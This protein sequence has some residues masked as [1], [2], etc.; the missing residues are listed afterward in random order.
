MIFRWNMMSPTAMMLTSTGWGAGVGSGVGSRVG[1]AVGSAVGS[2]VGSAAGSG[3]GSAVGSGSAVGDAASSVWTGLMIGWD[4]TPKLPQ[5]VS[6]TQ[7]D[8]KRIALTRF[9]VII[10]LFIAF[11]TICRN[12][13]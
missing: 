5:P 8:I 2:T 3:V 10:P 9:I 6:S 4:V 12:A 7:S 1:S 13:P 11:I